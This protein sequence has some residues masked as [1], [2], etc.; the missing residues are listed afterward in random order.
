MFLYLVRHG[1]TPWNVEQRILGATD[2]GLSESGLRQA[3]ALA[4]F[5]CD[6]PIRAI[7]SSDLK[8]ALRTAEALARPH[9]LEVRALP[10]LREMD[11]GILEGLTLEEL[12]E[13]HP[14]F[15]EAWKKDPS[16]VTVPGGESLAQL[17]ERAWET[18]SGLAK[19]HRKGTIAV[20]SHNLAIVVFLC[21]LLGVPLRRFRQLRQGYTGVNLLEFGPL[22][23]AVH[24]MNVMTHL[25]GLDG[26][27]DPALRD[28]TDQYRE[29]EP[30]WSPEGGSA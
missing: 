20:V 28:P 2:I 18:I 8:R 24:Y 30:S 17:Q 4:G 21:R 10:G 23:W 3:E 29:G 13:N 27:L 14:D 9:A 25:H 1:E 26:Y 11:Q 6:R 12:M 7:Y 5:L 16:A 15:L 22:G 19:T